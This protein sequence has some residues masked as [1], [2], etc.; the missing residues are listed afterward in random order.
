MDVFKSCGITTGDNPQTVIDRIVNEK[1]KHNNQ[2]VVLIID[3]NGDVI[4]MYNDWDGL[5]TNTKALNSNRFNSPVNKGKKITWIGLPENEDEKN[6]IRIEVIFIKR[7]SNTNI[8][9]RDSYV[10]NAYENVVTAKVKNII[11][12]Q[13]M[14]EPYNITYSFVNLKGEREFRTID[15]VLTISR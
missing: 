9:K 4:S 2:Y 13:S 15:P 1:L 3:S 11:T 7:P 10:R 14:V 12:D 8:L 6:E 5:V